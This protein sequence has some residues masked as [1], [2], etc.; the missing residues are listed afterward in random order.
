M[1]FGMVGFFDGVFGFCCV[2]GI[3]E[4]LILMKGLYDGCD[5]FFLMILLIIVLVRV[6]VVIG[7][8]VEDLVVGKD[9]I[10]DNVIK[11]ELL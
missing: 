9:F 7:V 1:I 10:V 4:G 2:V 8:G 3:V 5:G 11:E 6:G